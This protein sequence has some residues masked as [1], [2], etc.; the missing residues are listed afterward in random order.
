MGR[1]Y[2]KR[3]KECCNTYSSCMFLAICMHDVIPDA[4]QFPFSLAGHRRQERLSPFQYKFC[5]V[6]TTL[7]DQREKEIK[8]KEITLS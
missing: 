2:V 1:V 7:R 6:P 3:A 4:R 8:E 5:S